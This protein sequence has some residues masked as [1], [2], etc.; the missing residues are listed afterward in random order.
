MRVLF[1]LL[2]ATACRA[3]PAP[4]APPL[5]LV[6]RVTA[7][8]DA[9]QPLP[10]IIAIHGLGDDPANFIRLFDELPFP[11]RVVAPRAP[12][13]HGR[14]ASWFP[15]RRLPPPAEDP[16]MTEGIRASTERLAALARWL[17]RHRPTRGRPI[18]T[19]FSQGGILSFALAAKH[20]E[21]IAA[22]IP[23]AGA[24]PASLL[25]TR[26]VP[27]PVTALHGSDD[28]VIRLDWAEA[29]LTGFPGAE[30]RRYPGVP[31][32]ITPAMRRDLFDLLRKAAAP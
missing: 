27:V 13:P 6:E 15:V 21:A 20:P 24:L 14:G 8:A 31:H 7:G 18:V 11:A 9:G 28:P 19:G 16:A 23:I 30:L 1:L 26:S 10:L 25:P 22:A 12:T 17:T 32:R 2:L 5:E 4:D 3:A 29:T